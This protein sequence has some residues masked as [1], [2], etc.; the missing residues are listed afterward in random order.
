M[1]VMRPLILPLLLHQTC[2][3]TNL[4]RDLVMRET[5]SAEDGNL[6]PTR[7]R[8]HGVDGADAGRDH[9]FGVDAGVGVDGRA[10]DVE[11]V[12]R[13]HLGS[14]VNGAAGAVEDAAQHVFAHAELEVVPRK[15]DFGLERVHQLRSPK[16]PYGMGMFHLLDIDARRAF[17]YLHHRPV[18][19]SP[20]SAI[21]NFVSSHPSSLVPLASST[22]PLRSEPSGSVKDT[23]SLNRGNLTCPVQISHLPP[24]QAPRVRI[25]FSKITRGPLTPPIVL[26]RMR[27]CIDVIRWSSSP[28]MTVAAA[29]RGAVNGSLARVVV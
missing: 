5:G 29:L 13:Q 10:V 12:L 24:H 3:P 21:C 16:V 19:C 4:R 11:V 20:T 14:F 8:V 2:L 18:A 6:L 25:T 27:G 17:E 28:A 1:I 9:L 22:C 15:L 26:Y 7:D 23:I